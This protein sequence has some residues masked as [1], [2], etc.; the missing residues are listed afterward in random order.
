MAAPGQPGG[1]S[2]LPIGCGK[3]GNI[4]DAPIPKDCKVISVQA[5]NIP[6][7]E[8]LI[9]EKI[10]KEWKLAGRREEYLN[11]SRV[12][13]YIQK[14]YKGTPPEYPAGALIVDFGRYFVPLP[15]EKST[16]RPKK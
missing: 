11:G 14:L 6:Q 1:V 5:D 4:I 16:L 8:T 2:T 15:S 9:Q 12:V 10:S 13:R 7:L 3:S